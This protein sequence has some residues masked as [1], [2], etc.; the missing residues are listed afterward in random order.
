MKS[1]FADRRVQ[2]NLAGYYTTY[3]GIQLNFQVGTSPTL[4]NAGAAEIYGFEAELQTRPI[5]ALTLSA[6][7]GYSNASYTELSPFVT[8]VTLNSALP[9]TPD[10]K[11]TFSPQYTIDLG[12]GGEVLL[13]A[14]YT[15]TSSLYNDTE[16][17]P[18]L[19]RP[20]TNMLNASVTYREPEGNWELA[21]GGTNLTDDRY[22]TTGQNQV[23]G[24]VTYGT[25]SRPREW[26]LTG[27]VHF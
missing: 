24:G 4:Q 13:S 7:L 26:Y 9:K 8:G 27:R 18:L 10:W 20:S 21:L 6:G 14:D 12:N 17:T 2:L 16:N 15:F 23:A 1:E 11:F 5:P 25:F 22:L 3:N 19:R